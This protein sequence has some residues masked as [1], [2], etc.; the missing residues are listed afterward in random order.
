MMNC[1]FSSRPS[2]VKELYLGDRGGRLMVNSLP[3]HKDF[4]SVSCEEDDKRG[5]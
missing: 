2:S 1:S 5:Q 3:G 4:T